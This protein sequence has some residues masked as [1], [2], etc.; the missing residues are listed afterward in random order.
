MKVTRDEGE[1]P[2]LISTMNAG[3][4]R[5][6]IADDLY[7]SSRVTGIYAVNTLPEFGL[8]PGHGIIANTDVWGSEGTHWIAIFR[9]PKDGHVEF[10][11]SFGRRPENYDIG[12]K[13][14]L[15][16][17]CTSI[18][19]NS[20]S[21]QD[22]YSSTCALYVLYYLFYRTRGQSMSDIVSCFSASSIINEALVNHF[23][24]GLNG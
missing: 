16:L 17:N 24:D 21:L 20:R 22:K 12:F 6:V 13:N 23:A 15:T 8:C 1:D 18:T 3:Q 5:R 10:F 2:L 14:F 4:M 9:D 7:L 11:D 19:Y